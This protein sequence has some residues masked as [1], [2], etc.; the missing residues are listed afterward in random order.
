MEPGKI[1]YCLFLHYLTQ[2]HREG[3]IDDKT[4][5]KLEKEEA[6]IQAAAKELEKRVMKAGAYVVVC[7]VLVLGF[8][9]L[10]RASGVPSSSQL[11]TTKY[12]PQS[13]KEICGNKGQV[14]KLQGW[15]HDW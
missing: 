1:I 12:A 6:K 9:Y 4:R 14:E 7:F 8:Q 2:K 15:L 5:E 10:Y 11:W 13:L 3:F